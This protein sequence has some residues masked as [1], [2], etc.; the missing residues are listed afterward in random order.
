VAEQKQHFAFRKENRVLKRPDF[1]Q[2]YETGISYRRRAAHVFVAPRENPTLPT[3]LGIT[4]TRKVGGAVQRN[5]LKRR[6][7]EI[8]RLAL[9][10]LRSGFTIIMNFHRAANEMSYRAIERDLFSAWREAG[11]LTNELD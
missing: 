6:G 1:L 10:Q 5:R 4:V 3:R 8:F 9:P 2:T 7:R 11:L